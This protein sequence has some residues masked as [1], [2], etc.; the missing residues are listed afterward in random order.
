MK[1]LQY[2]IVP[3]L[4]GLFF[5]ACNN[6]PKGPSQAELDTQVEAK[7][8]ATQDQL[9]ADCDTRLMQAAQLKADSMLVKMVNKKSPAPA[10]VVSAPG[11]KNTTPQPP[12]QTTPPPVKDKPKGLKSLSDQAKQESGKGGGLKSLSDQTKKEAAEKTPTKKGGLKS[13]SD[14]SK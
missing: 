4:A 6:E 12:K 7:V 11:P 9:K 14:Q 3:A 13:L 5:T 8:K 2:I 10:K 1:K